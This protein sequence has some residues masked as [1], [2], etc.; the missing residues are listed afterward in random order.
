[1]WIVVPGC[2]KLLGE[3]AV[4]VYG[5]DRGRS[6]LTRPHPD[7]SLRE[8]A[9]RNWPAVAAFETPRHGVF[10]FD[11]PTHVSRLNQHYARFADSIRCEQRSNRSGPRATSDWLD[12]VGEHGTRH[13]PMLPS[14][15]LNVTFNSCVAPVVSGNLFRSSSVCHRRC[16]TMRRW[17]FEAWLR[18]PMAIATGL[19]VT[20]LLCHREKRSQALRGRNLTR[21]IPA[22]GAPM[23]PQALVGL[24]RQGPLCSPIGHRSS[25]LQNP[26]GPGAEPLAIHAGGC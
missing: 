24:G 14:L 3:F 9:D 17:I 6:C 16:Q 12:A 11:R 4:F 26:G 21:N 10:Q 1:M 13:A 18:C 23:A 7:P 2:R 22:S 19:G 8:S 15:S 5:F 20:V 25:C